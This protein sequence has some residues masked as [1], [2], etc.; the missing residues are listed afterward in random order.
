MQGYP[1]F[2]MKLSIALIQPE[3]FRPDALSALRARQ[4]SCLYMIEQSNAG[5]STREALLFAGSA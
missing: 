2:W 1:L 4:V 3:P 5:P